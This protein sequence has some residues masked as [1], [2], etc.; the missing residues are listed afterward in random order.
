[1]D[2]LLVLILVD[3]FYPISVIR[4]AKILYWCNTVI[5]VC[6]IWTEIMQGAVTIEM[7]G[8]ISEKIPFIVL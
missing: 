1:M 2:Q 3:I 6:D 4:S 8:G 5:F 7:D